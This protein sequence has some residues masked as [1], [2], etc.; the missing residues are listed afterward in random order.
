MD[1]TDKMYTL[2]QDTLTTMAFEVKKAPM[3]DRAALFPELAKAQRAVAEYQAMILKNRTLTTEA[4]MQDLAGIK[5]EI[6][7][8]ADKQQLFNAI[9][10]TIAFVATRW[11]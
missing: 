3:A 1:H 11:V 10:R 6:E 5:A 8:A 7:R 9:G 4:D 2:L